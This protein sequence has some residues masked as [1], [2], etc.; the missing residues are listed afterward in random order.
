MRARMTE[1]F[2]NIEKPLSAALAEMAGSI[3][4]ETISVRDLL[5]ELGEQGMLMCSI[6]L[7]IPFLVPVS[8]PGVSTVFGLVITLIGVGVT[9]NRMP[10]LPK[11]LLDRQVATAPLSAAF[12]KGSRLLAR[13]ERFIHP[14]LRALTRGDRIAR[15]NGLMLVLGGLLLMVPFSF[16]PFSNTLPGLAILFLAIG[17]LQQ[18]GAFV[19]LGYLAILATIVYFGILAGAAIAAGWVGWQKLFGS[20]ILFW[21]LT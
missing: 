9:A 20:G 21:P 4:S 13:M 14:R 16:V 11:R 3:R 19:L 10:R 7:I 18:D 6:F 8:I 1:Q 15:F 5:E 17:M 2:H 12:E